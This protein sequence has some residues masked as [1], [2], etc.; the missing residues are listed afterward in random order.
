L[1]WKRKKTTAY[2]ISAAGLSH[3]HVQACFSL[4]FLVIQKKQQTN[5]N[6]KKK[7]NKGL[8]KSYV[9]WPASD[10]PLATKIL[11]LDGAE[12]NFT[13]DSLM[14]KKLELESLSS[15]FKMSGLKLLLN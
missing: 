1:Y 14:S 11:V 10:Y 4:V 15:A 2:H 12:V 9:V 6:N 8:S 13:E 3:I 7:P 5:N